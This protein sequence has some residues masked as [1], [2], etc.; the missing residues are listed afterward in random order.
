MWKICSVI[1]K[2]NFKD[3]TQGW[4]QTTVV[5]GCAAAEV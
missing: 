5:Y 1:N 2:S 3:N 4:R